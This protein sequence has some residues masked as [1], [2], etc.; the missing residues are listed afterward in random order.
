[1]RSFFADAIAPN[2]FLREILLTVY[3]EQLYLAC[4]A[5]ADLS[6]ANSSP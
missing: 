3:R 6:G 1:L 5:D 4:Q 2:P